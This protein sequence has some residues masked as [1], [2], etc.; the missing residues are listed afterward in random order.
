MAAFLNANEV[1]Q[2]LV[3]DDDDDNSEEVQNVEVEEGIAEKLKECLS[4]LS[5]AENEHDRKNRFIE[6]AIQELVFLWDF[7][8]NGSS[9]R[10]LLSQPI[11]SGVLIL[12]EANIW[13]RGIHRRLTGRRSLRRPFYAEIHRSIPRSIFNVIVRVVKS[14]DGFAQPFCFHSKNRK[15]EVISLTSIRLVKELFSLL[16]G[17]SGA[18]VMDFFKRKLTSGMRSGHKVSVLVDEHKDFAF[19]YKYNKGELTISYNFGEWNVCGTPQHN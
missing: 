3:D 17:L 8:K 14:S 9:A 19:I 6:S 15:G 2:M 12:D 18:E 13:L 4:G 16:S 1:A 10:S 5:V 11:N 7:S